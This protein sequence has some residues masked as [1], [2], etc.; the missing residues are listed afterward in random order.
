[1]IDN[2]LRDRL[3]GIADQV[4]APDIDGAGL[5]GRVRRR[6][7]MRSA[8]KGVLVL[9]C[10]AVA[11]AGISWQPWSRGRTEAETVQA[12]ASGNVPKSAA[13]GTRSPGFACGD[14]VGA[15]AA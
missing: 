2:Q 1:M 7:R 9:A 5:V 3:N 12:S 15:G 4:D 14:Q 6:R 10:A 11:V 8:K 13:T